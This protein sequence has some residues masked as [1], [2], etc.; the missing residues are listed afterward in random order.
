MFDWLEKNPF[1]F[2]V[3]VFVVIAVAGLIEAIPDFAQGSRPVAGLK[4]Y[5]LLELAGREIYIKDSC[6][7]C[8]SQLIRP[9]KSETDRYGKYSLSGEYAYD[10]PFLWGSKRTGP[11]LH[12]VGNYRTSDWHANH[13]WDPTSVVP[14]SIMPAY[15]HMFTNVTDIE[16]AYAEA[17]TVKKVFNVP[18]DA[19][20]DGDGKVDVPLGSF[21]EAKA[22]ALKYAMKVAKETKREDLVNMV[23]EGKIPEI[24]ALIAY[25]NR[26]K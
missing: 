11:D 23:K 13:M 22:R 9:F 19:D 10:R 18:Y 14:N 20:I 15:K 16:T 8:H 24:V 2:A 17:V 5:S 12:R 1:F 21:E 3:G 26:L 6:N 4:P 25:L 7:A